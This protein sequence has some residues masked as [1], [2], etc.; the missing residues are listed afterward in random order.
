VGDVYTYTNYS[1]LQISEIDIDSGIFVKYTVKGA[2]MNNSFINVTPIIGFIE[3]INDYTPI[4]IY[5]GN[6]ELWE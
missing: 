2:Y 5:L 1:K 3:L 4:S 6:E